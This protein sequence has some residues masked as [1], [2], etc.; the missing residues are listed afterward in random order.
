MLIVDRNNGLLNIGFV[1]LC[2]RVCNTILFPSK[3][4]QVTQGQQAVSEKKIF[5]IVDAERTP[6]QTDWYTISSP[7]EPLAQ[8]S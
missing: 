5:E 7:C 1:T 8:V 6:D 2:N 4:D 3:L